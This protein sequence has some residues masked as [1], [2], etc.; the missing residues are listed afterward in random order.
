[1]STKIFIFF[2]T[3]LFCAISTVY[4]WAG[5][6][7]QA[8][9]EYDD[10]Y[11]LGNKHFIVDDISHLKWYNCYYLGSYYNEIFT[12]DLEDSTLLT[13]FGLRNINFNNSFQD[14]SQYRNK[15]IK[16]IAWVSSTSGVDW[17]K[18]SWKDYTNAVYWLSDTPDRKIELVNNAS[19][20]KRNHT[21][22][23]L[24]VVV[25]SIDINLKNKIKWFIERFDKMQSKIL[26]IDERVHKYKHILKKVDL[27]HEKKI[28]KTYQDVFSV[29]K[30]EL[31]EKYVQLEYDKCLLY[32]FFAPAKKE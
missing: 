8:K 25:N 11:T 31:W 15:Y 12:I 21:A 14:I 4:A 6:W 22:W 9:L 17:F 10:C 20:C 24:W 23:F 18:W 7:A 1:M 29:I 26:S 19:M 32:S 2:T 27:L 28:S 30:L 16:I 5:Y 13:K 3:L